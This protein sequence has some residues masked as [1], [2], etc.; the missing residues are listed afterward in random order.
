MNKNKYKIRK[1]RKLLTKEII[2]SCNIL[3]ERMERTENVSVNN[4]YKMIK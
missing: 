2:V 4:M 3:L 1:V